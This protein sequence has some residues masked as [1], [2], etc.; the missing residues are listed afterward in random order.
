MSPIAT[1]TIA[2]TLYRPVS[3]T[4]ACGTP[5]QNG[6]SIVALPEAHF[7]GG[8]HCGQH[9]NVEYN[10]RTIDATVGDLCRTCLV[11]GIELSEGAFSAIEKLNVG[12][13]TVNWSFK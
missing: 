7:E 10:G 3:R 13:V 11:D 8:A 9:L 6:A 1:D 12:R 4:S 2:A 5:L